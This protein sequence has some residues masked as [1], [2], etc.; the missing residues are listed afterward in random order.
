MVSVPGAVVTHRQE[1]G[2]GRFFRRHFEYGRGA[3]RVRALA[4]A[5]TGSRIRLEPRSFYW[6]LLA[7]P[8]SI[9]PWPRGALV[10]GLVALSQFASALGFLAE[11]L[12]P[13][14]ADVRLQENSIGRN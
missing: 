8:L 7:Q 9:A 6:R 10:A 2:L 11:H 5:S 12:S 3:Y 4:A 13:S 14:T 1:S